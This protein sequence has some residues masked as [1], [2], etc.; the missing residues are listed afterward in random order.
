MI[1]ANPP[2]WNVDNWVRQLTL[3]ALLLA[4]LALLGL[5]IALYAPHAHA[6]PSAVC[7]YSTSERTLQ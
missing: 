3:S 4:A 7:T 2:Q 1:R 6:Q 5:A